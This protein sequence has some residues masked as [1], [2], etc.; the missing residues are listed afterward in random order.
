MKVVFVNRFYW[1]EIPAT[2]QL[3][4]DLAQGLAARDWEVSVITSAAHPGVPRLEWHCGVN[5]LR[6]GGTRWARRGTLGKAV[7]F[8]T[9]FLGATRRVFMLAGPDTIVVPMTDPPLLGVGVELAAACRGARTVHWIQDIYPE[10][11]TAL[12]RHSWLGILRPLRNL[13][14]RKA[15]AC[16]TVGRDMAQAVTRAAVC[17]ERV[18]VA[19]NWAPEGISPLAPTAPNPLRKERGLNGKF[20]VAYS[21]NLGRVHDLDPIIGLAATL[22]TDPDVVVVFIGDGV[23][24]PRLEAAARARS[25][26]NVAFFPPQ[27][28]DRLSESLALGDLHLVTLRPGCEGYVFPSKLY[29]IAAAGRPIAFVGPPDCE[30]AGIIREYGL[31]L[32]FPRDDIAG[33]AAGVRRLAADAAARSQYSAAALA[34]A[35][36]H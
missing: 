22:H 6:V 12:L 29:G 10:V 14:W 33:L 5:I 13:A 35:A 20:V 15:A 30:V 26:A 7:D 21:G 31:G 17:P 2:G 34:F 23:Q 24:R 19:P 27:P 1:P 11:A 4:T 16:V 3:L 9:F 36:Q 18:H 32:T 28:R 25:L 8:G